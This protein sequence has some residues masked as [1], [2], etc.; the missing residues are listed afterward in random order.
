MKRFTTLL[1]GAYALT[2]SA[3]INLD[4]YTEIQLG[5]DYPLTELA[6]FRGKFTAPASGTVVEYAT[7]PV[8]QLDESTMELVGLEDSSWQY[9]GYING[10]QAYQFN[11]TQ[12]TTY[13]FE[14][15]FVING[16]VFR[17]E[18]NSP[19]TLIN[20]EPTIG[21]TY[22]PA[23]SD[24]ILLVFNQNVL[25]SE[26]TISAAGKTAVC[27]SRN[28]GSSV[29]IDA[30]DVLRSWYAQGVITG[31][32]ELTVT[33]KDLTTADGTAYTE[34]D[35]NGVF[36]FIAVS[37]P[38]ELVS[39]QLP[40]SISSYYPQSSTDSQM[41]FTFSGPIEANPQVQLCYNLLDI[42]FEYVE[43]LPTN[44]SGNTVTVDLAGKRRA[45]SDMSTSGT[46]SNVIYVR[47]LKLNDAQGHSVWSSGQGTTG[48]FYY[49]VPFINIERV[50]VLSEFTPA[51][52]SDITNEQKINIW[53]NN[54]NSLTYDGVR[55]TSG[56]ESTVVPLADL[57]RINS[58]DDE[59]EIN[60]N[61]P[62]GWNTKSNVVVTL[63]NLRANDGYD[64]T[65]DIT[66]TFNGFV[67]TYINPAD[68]SKIASIQKGQL[69]VAEINLA[70]R[71][72][73]MK[74]TAALTCGDETIFS[75]TEMTR[76]ADDSYALTLADDVTMYTGSDYV[77]TLVATNA[78]EELGS[79]SFTY[80][81]ATAPFAFSEFFFENVN[82]AEGSTLSADN[83]SF[84][85]TFDGLA[86]VYATD[87][88]QFSSIAPVDAT[89]EGVSNV[90]RLTLSPKAVADAQA[91]DGT[92]TVSFS[93][94]D[95]LL[96][97]IEGNTGTDGDSHFEFNYVI[98][99]S[100]ISEITA[101]TIA[102]T[103]I[104]DLQGRR[105]SAI[106]RPGIYLVNGKKL[107]F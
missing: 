5:T 20:S 98:G 81:G 33:L 77:L 78:G 28:N 3:A 30:T 54:A 43:N 52:G 67:V 49:E 48:S 66:A 60:V 26:V 1:I 100:S 39:A 82:P 21:T 17:I 51:N 64:H 13:I 103:T 80:H 97:L 57:Q 92:I 107:K 16:G 9:S 106:T 74:V 101:D 40:A 62:Q 86:Y 88:A 95:L 69:I 56:S 34:N 38:V 102:N 53:F 24:H 8:F 47:L 37:T 94:Y 70:D 23:E 42:D 96:N 83:A 91:A 29:A 68:D 104:Y 76:R 41:Q 2:A 59:E 87:N 31:G 73:D 65:N 35:G 75:T 72:P 55:F 50:N 10:K 7:V 79:A 44:V 90:W 25:F 19:I 27:E 15:K 11:A 18:M 89:T 85:A 45:A 93:A 105:V 84:T 58:R 46:V 61:I 71:Y 14:D 63:E 12:G 6:A 36:K 4:D 22:S 99:A 32:E